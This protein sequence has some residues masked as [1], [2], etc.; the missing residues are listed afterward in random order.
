MVARVL[1]GCWRR[2]P[3]P[4][5]IDEA[6]LQEILPLLLSGGCGSLIWRS[7]RKTELGARPFAGEL[8]DLHRYCALQNAVHSLALKEALTYLRTQG[9]EPLLVKGWS[10]GPLY[11]E[12]GLRPFGD[13]DFC[14]R[15]AEYEA[16]ATALR[17]FNNKGTSIDLHSGF[18]KFYDPD[19][20]ALFARSQLVAL[21]DVEVRIPGF[22]DHLRFL[23]LHL[24]RHG[25][26]RPL[27]LCDIAAALEALPEDFDWD[28]CLGDRQPQI[29]WVL[30]ALGLAHHL[31]GVRIPFEP[32]LPRWLLPTVLAA[33]EVPFALPPPVAIFL[34]QP[35]QL[36]KELPRH[37]PNP[38][39]AT[40]ALNGGF[41]E[42]PRWPYQIGGVL[43]KTA[44]LLVQTR[45]LTRRG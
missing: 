40:L 26:G 2:D 1:T 7:I 8:R 9:I 12:P 41:N 37:W 19:V 31:L 39:E 16:A 27:W 11:P 4:L 25:A 13:I 22:E 17:S 33:W 6:S 5:E 45:G 21:D 29:D 36:L 20:D 34:H 24:L 43:A 32:R 15:P 14:V 35:R 42:W 38:I 44:R 23:C 18:A 3:S 10:L 28:R 30:G